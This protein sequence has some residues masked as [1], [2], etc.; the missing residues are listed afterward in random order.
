MDPVHVAEHV[1]FKEQEQLVNRH[2]NRGKSVRF[3]IITFPE[4]IIFALLRVYP[5]SIEK[6]KYNK[7]GNAQLIQ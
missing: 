3:E 5:V 1:W 7:P 4:S 6:E 2:C